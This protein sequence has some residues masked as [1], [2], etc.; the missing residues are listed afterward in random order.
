MPAEKIRRELIFG[1]NTDLE[2]V[3]REVAILE[4]NL[5]QAK[6]AE[7]EARAEGDEHRLS[8]VRQ[9]R[10]LESLKRE[11]RLARS[12]LKEYS[13]QQKE[14]RDSFDEMIMS[15]NLQTA[16]FEAGMKV[17]GGVIGKIGE[18]IDKGT[19]W[20]KITGELETQTQQLAKVTDELI[21]EPA[22]AK[23][24]KY[25]KEL[26]LT[27]IQMNTMAKAA[28]QLGRTTDEDFGKALE[29]II[30]M[31]LGGSFEEG[32]EK[33]GI[34]LDT[35]TGTKMEQSAEVL[36]V[37]TE[38]FGD[39]QVS[40]QNASEESVKFAN[41]Q[42]SLEGRMG[43]TII[44]STA[45]RKSIELITKSKEW[46]I[47][48]TT[49]TIYYLTELQDEMVYAIKY[50]LGPFSDAI[51]TIAESLG[52]AEGHLQKLINGMKGT[53]TVVIKSVSQTLSELE[54]ETEAIVKGG[55]RVASAVIKTREKILAASKKMDEKENREAEQKR[56]KAKREK[57][58]EDREAQ[59]R[60]QRALRYQQRARESY[61]RKLT[62]V[63][64]DQANQQIEIAK[65]LEASEEKRIKREAQ[66][67][68]K[69]IARI[70]EHTS[71]FYQAAVA[72]AISAES[73][74]QFMEKMAADTLN[75][76]GQLAI[77]QAI[78]E[79]ALALG[80]LGMWDF[81]GAANHFAS[82][83]M[84][85]ALGIGTQVAGAAVHSGIAAEEKK[86]EEEKKEREK[87]REDEE[88]RREKE[89]GSSYRSSSISSSREQERSNVPTQVNNYYIQGRSDLLT[90]K[91]IQQISK[92]LAQG[93]S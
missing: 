22:L 77:K 9:Q 29:S 8:M 20:S 19:E 3:N 42:E 24:V 61:E 49:N 16:A 11:Q 52:I 62:Q 25:K 63:K 78:K 92:K 30:D 23:L 4:K 60:E 17:I 76:L 56:E 83:A 72:N 2:K 70:E 75:Y 86:R 32:M 6:W 14:A 54:K 13:D 90:R 40:V 81:A 80:S 31:V 47:K 79:T 28:I 41:R 73:F 71:A 46:L 88:K 59:R 51:M 50:G 48:T 69:R 64:K 5:N 45:Y 26:G 15:F 82:A 18:I 87:E 27:E 38:K 10:A 89:S 68:E 43:R 7:R 36:R 93:R 91:D 34:Q 1:I 55:P 58:K 84:W 67:H 44:S 33:L 21:P 66:E 39:M 74:G 12:A 37:L 35:I 85:G 65:N 57:E 53:E